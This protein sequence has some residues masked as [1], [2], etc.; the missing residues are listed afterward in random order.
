MHFFPLNKTPR[1]LQEAIRSSTFHSRPGREN[2]CVMSAGFRSP[3]KPSRPGIVF[4][5]EL[6]G[7]G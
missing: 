7:S 5:A 6:Q 4:P 2:G 1:N 3:G